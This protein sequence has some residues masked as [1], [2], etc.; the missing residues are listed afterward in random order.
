MPCRHV[1]SNNNISQS[2]SFH[3]TSK[4]FENTSGYS[5]GE[6]IV[7]QQ[8]YYVYMIQSVFIKKYNVL[9]LSFS[10]SL[11]YAVKMHYGIIYIFY[12]QVLPRSGPRIS[13]GKSIYHVGDRVSVNCTSERSKPAATLHWSINNQAVRN[14][15]FLKRFCVIFQWNF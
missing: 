3:S 6:I 5:I 11:L 13:G 8:F 14:I 2:K 7:F 9:T 10:Q 1:V 12:T 15:F 4:S